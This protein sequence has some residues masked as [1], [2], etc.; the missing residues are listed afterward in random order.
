[1]TLAK[2]VAN[3]PGPALHPLLGWRK[4]AFDFARDSVGA[5]HTLHDQYGSIVQLGQGKMS[6]TFTFDPEYT[7]QI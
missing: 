1:M 3:I 4:F 6:A 5:L 2:S 7:R